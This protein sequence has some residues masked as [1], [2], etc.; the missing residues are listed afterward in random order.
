MRAC[1]TRRVPPPTAAQQPCAPWRAVGSGAPR[2]TRASQL[3]RLT[4][5]PKPHD[6]PRPPQDFAEYVQAL[7]KHV[8]TLH[9]ALLVITLA[10]SA[11]FVFGRLRPVVRRQR[12]QSKLVSARAARG[13]HLRDMRVQ[14]RAGVGGGGRGSC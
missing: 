12:M 6:A 3:W 5:F 14:R 13:V 2:R 10:F 1:T 11:W 9:V 8:R 7:F 4:C